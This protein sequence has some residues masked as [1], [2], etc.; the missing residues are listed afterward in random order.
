MEARNND[1]SAG[2]RQRIGTCTLSTIR[3]IASLN[4]AQTRILFQ[5]SIEHP[6]TTDHYYRQQNRGS[7]LYLLAATTHRSYISFH[8]SLSYRRELI[9]QHHT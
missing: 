9:C 3:R 6:A 2:R 5:K 7:R 4:P 1:G 8:S